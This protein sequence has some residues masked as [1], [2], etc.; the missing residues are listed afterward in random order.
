MAKHIS[1]D[2]VVCS[3]NQ[4]GNP[5]GNLLG[6]LLGNPQRNVASEGIAE[7]LGEHM[8]PKEFENISIEAFESK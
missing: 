1:P 6:N 5:L 3:D 2:S 8:N 7:H 4:P